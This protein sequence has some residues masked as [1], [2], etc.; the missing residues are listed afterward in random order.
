MFARYGVPE[1]WI[2]DPVAATIE[3]YDARR[4]LAAR[5]APRSVLLRVA[6]DDGS[7][8]TGLERRVTRRE[9]LPARIDDLT[10]EVSQLGT[11]MRNESSAFRDDMRDW[12][13]MEF[14]AL[15]ALMRALHED[16]IGRL[17]LLQEALTAPKR[18]PKKK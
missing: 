2:V 3:I 8:V 4:A 17:D 9:E 7:V 6:V 10:S 11:E 18:R 13:R 5:S 15:S 1:Y 16:L 12:M 14:G